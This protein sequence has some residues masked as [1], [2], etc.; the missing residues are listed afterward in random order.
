MR[1]ITAADDHDVLYGV[2]FVFYLLE[3]HVRVF[4]GRYHRDNVLFHEAEFAVRYVGGVSALDRADEHIAVQ[5]SGDLL[6]GE[7][8]KRAALGELE[9]QQLDPAF[10]ECVYFQRGREAQYPRYLRRGSLFGVYDHGESELLF[11]VRRFG[12]VLRASYSCYGLAVTGFFRDEAA[13]QVQLVRAGHR[14]Q[15]IGCA[16]SG[17]LL[18]DMRGAVA[19]DTENVISRGGLVDL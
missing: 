9:F 18:R 8:L 10:C 17:F 1:Y 11:E 5:L 2:R 12:A 13:E 15:K 19:D 16:Y 7:T 4:R 14:D 6:Y 3:E